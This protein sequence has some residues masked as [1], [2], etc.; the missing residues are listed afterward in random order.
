[1]REVRDKIEE[2]RKLSPREQQQFMESHPI[3]AVVGPDGGHYVTDH[4]HLSRAALESGVKV[5]LVEIEA[6]LSSHRDDFW[7]EMDRRAWVHPLDQNGV[8]H[9][10]DAI[11]GHLQE[12]VDDVYRSLARYVRGAG[13]YEK[14][15]AAFAE[16]VWADYFRRLIAIED[17]RADFEAA[18]RAGVKLAR[19]DRATAMPG[20][21]GAH[22]AK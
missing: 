21:W 19:S 5:G 20:F 8:R 15:A 7:A 13:G 10:Y 4:H 11:P 1:M 6:D 22:E 12:L 14:T 18:V 17:V 9:R 2:L 16:F 3:P